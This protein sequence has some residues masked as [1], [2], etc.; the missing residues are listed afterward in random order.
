MT[1]AY[2]RR[3]INMAVIIERVMSTARSLSVSTGKG[4]GAGVGDISKGRRPPEKRKLQAKK[5]SRKDDASEFF[6]GD[7]G[8]MV[9]ANIHH[10]QLS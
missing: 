6:F 4:S 3:D 2:I 1:L 10:P 5:N 9:N 7:E 8:V